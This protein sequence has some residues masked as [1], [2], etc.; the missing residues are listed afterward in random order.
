[1]F[2]NR[3]MLCST[4]W[5]RALKNKAYKGTILGVTRAIKSAAFFR[6]FLVFSVAKSYSTSFLFHFSL[7]LEIR[8][9][10]KFASF[11][12][13]HDLRIAQLLLLL[14]LLFSICWNNP[15][16]VRFR[17]IS[18]NAWWNSSLAWDFKYRS[19]QVQY[20]VPYVK[21][22][23]LIWILPK[24]KEFIKIKTS[25]QR[26]LTNSFSII[27]FQIRGCV[28]ILIFHVV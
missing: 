12:F 3:W 9:G 23:L 24:Y 26:S 6:V 8:M 19:R 25:H 15:Y 21:R 4:K 17:N 2:L 11:I 10:Q 1:M 18:T 20:L 16:F 7:A 5:W 22:V 13:D 28:A 27:S 14:L